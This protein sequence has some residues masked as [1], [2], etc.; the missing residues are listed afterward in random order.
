ME[1]LMDLKWLIPEVNTFNEWL[2]DHW[3][4]A[5]R[6]Y[7]L[8]LNN[9]DLPQTT[10]KTKILNLSDLVQRMDDCSMGIRKALTKLE[11]IGVL[12]RYPWFEKF[13]YF[14]LKGTEPIPLTDNPLLPKNIQKPLRS[15]EKVSNIHFQDLAHLREILTRN[16]RNSLRIFNILSK[17][18]TSY[19][20]GFS[21]DNLIKILEQHNITLKNLARYIKPLKDTGV[22]FTYKNGQQMF[23]Q[24]RY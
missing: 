8:T 7:N 12:D 17:I 1:C 6:I 21:R 15:I 24:L 13:Y 18:E 22:L 3:L 23:Y 2:G 16:W 19:S 20:I 11:E 9:E 10:N 5:L 4:V 14:Q